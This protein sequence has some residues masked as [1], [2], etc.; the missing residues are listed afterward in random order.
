MKTKKILF[1]LAIVG[2]ICLNLFGTSQASVAQPSLICKWETDRCPGLFGKMR[3]I[4]VTSG[5]G[6]ECTCGEVTRDCNE[7]Q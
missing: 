1:G 5:N 3:E 6:F 7:P 4:C 2:V